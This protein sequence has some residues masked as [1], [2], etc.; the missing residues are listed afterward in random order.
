MRALLAVFL[1]LP[2]AG[3]MGS[4]DSVVFETGTQTLGFDSQGRGDPAPVPV[5]DCSE[6]LDALNARLIDSAQARLAH[7]LELGRVYPRWVS[8]DS[9]T[10]TVSSSPATGTGAADAEVTGT[11]NQEAGADEADLVK[12]DGQWTYVL[13]RGSL[14]VMHSDQVGDIT[15]V[16]SMDVAQGS[17]QLLLERGNPDD[18]LDDRLLVMVQSADPRIPA[19]GQGV[20][21]GA[22][23]LIG[24]AQQSLTRLL[25]LDMADRTDPVILDERYIEGQVAAARLVGGIAHV[26]VNTW[27][28]YLHLTQ[29]L[30]IDDDLLARSNLTWS[31]YSSL[32]EAERRPLLEKA[33]ARATAENMALVANLSLADHLPTVLVGDGDGY[34]TEPLTRKAC[35]RIIAPEDGTGRSVNTIWS[36]D[37]TSLEERTV[38]VLGSRPI[39]YAAPGALV[40]AEQSQDPWW[41]WDHRDTEEATNLHWFDLEGLNVHHRASGRIAGSVL[42]SFSLDVHEG[43]LRVITTTGQWGRWWLSDPEPMQN[44]LAV[45]HREGDRLVEVGAV[46][47]FAP[48]ERVWSARFTDSRAY[49]VTFRQI[50][51]LWIIDLQQTAPRILGE[52]EIP[53]VSTYL[54]PLDDERLLSIG[55]GP[56][57]DGEG[58]NFSRVQISLFDT[59]DASQPTRIQAL[60]VFP[61]AEGWSSSGATREHKAFTYWDRLGML[62][63]P[64]TSLR[65]DVH[66]E[67]GR[68][69]YHSDHHVGLRLITVDRDGL[70][71][72]GDVDQNHFIDGDRYW[73]AE[74]QRSHFLGFPEQWPERPVSVYAISDHGVTAH[75]LESLELQGSAMFAG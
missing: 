57:D 48:E 72:Y 31:A 43:Q 23:A 75:D 4:P 3:C 32:D 14:H 51:P 15:R 40:F 16:H 18:P 71:V 17:G 28:P 25:V 67:D 35:G 41:Y 33:H 39:V 11:N 13:S 42:D 63:V 54:H 44:H 56:R 68:A 62:A 45:F 37:M 59:S 22:P 70:S 47:G 50:D 46:S 8:T 55:L 2:L 69:I 6:V 64:V 60:D 9:A 10:N 74:V 36:L 66:W 7:D 21:M 73:R 5:G 12:T 26:V 65:H 30:R 34:T 53:G 52:L 38:Q 58:L 61:G 24:P 27:E 20:A 19:P 49:V 1:L 29:N